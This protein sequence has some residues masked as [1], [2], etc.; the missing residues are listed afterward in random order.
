[1][2]ED[3]EGASRVTCLYASISQAVVVVACLCLLFREYSVMCIGVTS[4]V[5]TSARRS[6]VDDSLVLAEQQEVIGKDRH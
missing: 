6:S 4:G 5:R 3:L 1:M 2:F